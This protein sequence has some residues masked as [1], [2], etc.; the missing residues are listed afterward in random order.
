MRTRVVLRRPNATATPVTITT[1]ATATAGDLADALVRA[2][3][4][5]AVDGAPELRIHRPD[6]VDFRRIRRA[7]SLT[8]AGFR[9]GSTIVVSARDASEGTSGSVAVARLVVVAGPDSGR[10][11][12]LG[13]GIATIGRGADCD[14]QLTDS[15]VSRLHARLLVGDQIEIIDAGS[16]NGVLIGD[17]PVTRGVVRPDDIIVLGT[18]Q[19]QVLVI[20]PDASHHK[21]GATGAVLAFNRSPRLVE[22]YPE[23]NVPAPEVPTPPQ[24][25]K[26]PMLALVAPVIMGTVMFSVT[27]NPMSLMFV[28]LSPMM[29]LGNWWSGRSTG[30]KKLAAETLAFAEGLDLLRQQIATDHAIEREARLAESPATRETVGAALGMAPVLWSARPRETGFGSIR[31]GTGTAPSRTTIDAPPRGQADATMWAELQAAMAEMADVPDVPHVAELTALGVLGIAGELAAAEP[32]ARAIMAQIACL[33]S[34]AELVIAGVASHASAARWEWLSWLPHVDS[35]HSPLSAHLATSPAACATVVTQLEELIAARLGVGGAR[36]DPALPWVVLL[37]E[38][39]APAERGRLVRIAE[40]GLAAGVLVIWRADTQRRLPASCRAVLV[41]EGTGARTGRTEDGIWYDIVPETLDAKAAMTLARHLAGVTDAGALTVDESDLPRAVGYLAVAGAEIASDPRAVIEQW[42]E[43]GSILNRTGDPVRRNSDAHLRGIIGQGTDGEFVLDLRSQGPHALVGGTTG[44]GKS[45]F[46]QAW[47]MGMAAAHS[48]DRVTFL[49]VD[50]K[51]GAAFADC[52]KLPHTV[53]LVTDLA[54]HLVRRAL[55]SLRAELRYREHLLAQ[56]QAKDLLALERTGDPRTPP[57]LIIVV[58]EFAA[59][60][61]EI[62]EFVDGVVDVAQRG[63]SLGLHLVLATQR[64]AG[65]IKDNL[66]ANTNLRIALRMADESDSSDVLGTPMAAHFDPRIPGRGAVRTGPGRLAMFQTGYVGGRSDSAPPPVSIG[67]ESLTFGPGEEWT[68]P[69]TPESLLPRPADGPTDAARIV[70]TLRRAATE[71]GIPAPRRPWLDEMPAVI[72][73]DTSSAHPDNRLPLGTVDVPAEQALVPFDY[74][75]DDDGPLA[76]YGSTGSGKSNTLRTLAVAAATAHGRV[77]IYALDFAGG[78]LEMIEAIPQV[79]SVISGQDTERVNRVLTDLTA[80]LDDRALRFSRSRA[81]TLTAYRDLSGRDEDRI[82][83]LLDGIAA[84]RDAYENQLGPTHFASFLRLIAEGRAVGIHVVITAERPNALTTAMAASISKRL[85]LRQADENAYGNLGVPKDVLNPE[86]NAGRAVLSGTSDTIQIATVG[87]HITP[88]R[89]A[90]AIKELADQLVADGA[91]AAAPVRHLPTHIGLDELPHHINDQPVLGIDSDDLA[92]IGFVRAGVLTLAG[93]SGSGR[94]TAL[95]TLG[96][97]LRRHADAPLYFAGPRGSIVAHVPGLW[98][99][100]AAGPT[101]VA[102]LAKELLPL[103]E[104]PANG[105]GH[106]LIIEGV[107]AHITGEADAPLLAI[108]RAARENGHL[109]IAEAETSTWASS[110]PLAGE[111]K[112]QRRGIVLQPEQGDG[113]LVVRTQFPRV[114]R[115]DN[116]PGRGLYAESGRV[117][118]IQ[119][120][121]NAT[122]PIESTPE[123]D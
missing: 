5:S 14:L 9:A 102:E 90:D 49:F 18:T 34:P 40:E 122:S 69:P 23:R 107:T 12:E 100:V 19:L 108:I 8:E 50:Y 39:D 78:A 42:N 16:A 1:D 33:H 116:P 17:G 57:A 67:I 10:E 74:S 91:H 58:D 62:P 7:T 118:L 26:F 111:L 22:R 88:K 56:A 38:D 86:S 92:P 115:I 87:G 117:H 97:S 80:E 31:L 25:T 45:E 120:P 101:E 123:H 72:R 84:F 48:P 11:I 55:T 96:Q 2:D 68:I 89:Q 103:F 105:T 6:D 13:A 82:F 70:E 51:G 95:I 61:Q 60:V 121:L 64:P 30:R 63:R 106:T 35:S 59:L 29:M 47:V 109:I 112:N 73:L 98:D 36:N 54:G 99:R 41:T 20:D 81:D 94:S 28:V 113:D 71:A 79:A 66:R 77:R 52:V 76:I 24:P 65:V 3:P 104:Q 85:V 15:Q 110:W 37:V 4:S 53:G 43:T 75:P 46:L 119:M 27:R 44:A 32:V 93:L 21:V 114:R 83:L